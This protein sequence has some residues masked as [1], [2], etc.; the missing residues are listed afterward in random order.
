MSSKT[1]VN[2]TDRDRPIRL[3]L[4]VMGADR[5]PAVIVQGGVDAALEFGLDVEIALI[6]REDEINALFDGGVERPD[7]VLVHHA[8]HV[9]NMDDSP[10]E[11]VRRTGTS[12]A[13][14]LQM[15]KA[16]EVDAFISPGN[17]GAVMAGALLALGR[18]T[19]VNR[20]A[21]CAVFPTAKFKPT[22]VLDVGANAVCKPPHLVQFAALGSAYA[23]AMHGNPSPRVGLL[24]IGE[25]RSKGH[26]LIFQSHQL[27]EN[28]K[29][30]FVGNIEG[31]DIL[32]G[33]LDVV[34]T[35]GFTGNVALKFAESIEGFLTRR[36]RHQISTNIFSRAGAMLM[37]PFLRRLRTAF[38]YAEAGG[39]PLLGINGVTLIC[40]GSSSPRAIKNGLATALQ[41]VKSELIEQTRELMKENDLLHIKTSGAALQSEAQRAARQ[42][43]KSERVN[44]APESVEAQQT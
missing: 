38:D 5:G 44:Q 7:N 11:A 9:I 25:E 6:G 40:H 16:G 30:N 17:T 42:K 31:R 8:P 4:D 1:L 10:A 3:A 28:S 43:R 34:V 24:S 36:L 2:G 23:M 14:G 29:L 41:M 32:S 27:L 35:D 37:A 18:L 26:D 19:G 39:A 20:P 13:V 21:I 15:H 22:I 33:D 12:V